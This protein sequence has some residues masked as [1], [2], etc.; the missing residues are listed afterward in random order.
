MLSMVVSMIYEKS[1]HH[2]SAIETVLKDSKKKTR[3]IPKK[4]IEINSHSHSFP[5]Q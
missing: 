2:F 3:S 5:Y 1:R 4:K